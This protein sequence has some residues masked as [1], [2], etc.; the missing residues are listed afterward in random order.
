MKFKIKKKGK[1][2]KKF[3]LNAFGVVVLVALLCVF[4]YNHFA[5]YR[6]KGFLNLD[7]KA[8]QVAFESTQN[9]FEF[10][11]TKCDFNPLFNVSQGGGICLMKIQALI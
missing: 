10:S 2:M 6:F 4:A 11:P 7:P 8:L 5:L 9:R 3:L 1:T